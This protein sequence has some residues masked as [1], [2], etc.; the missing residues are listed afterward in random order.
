M[1][2]VDASTIC[3][4]VTACVLFPFWGFLFFWAIYPR[5]GE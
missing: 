3:G 1:T 5:D 2:G 4:I